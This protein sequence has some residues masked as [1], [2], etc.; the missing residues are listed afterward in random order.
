MQT[1]IFISTFNLYI[2]GSLTLYKCF[3][4]AIFVRS[5]VC[6]LCFDRITRQERVAKL[7]QIHYPIR[8][9]NFVYRLLIEQVLVPLLAIWSRAERLVM[10]GNFPCAFWFGQQ[11]IF[12]HNVHYLQ[13]ATNAPS[14]KLFLEWRLF[15]FLMAWKKPR[16]LVQTETVA[17][18]FRAA[19]QTVRNIEVI[20][21]PNPFVE[22]E[23][24]AF[25]NTRA[26]NLGALR[27]IYPALF[28]PHK[29]HRMLFECADLL[30]AENV[31]VIL[32]IARDA[33][34]GELRTR[35]KLFQ[36]VGIL[37]RQDLIE[38]YKHSD[39]L[40]FPSLEESL[41]LPL[42]EAAVLSLP[43][44]APDLSYVHS[45]IENYYSYSPASNSAFIAVIRRLKRD[46]VQGQPKIPTSKVV[47][48]AEAFVNSLLQ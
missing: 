25:T 35:D 28:Y 5:D 29:N 30:E 48:S 36:C 27:L 10:M 11:T 40:L 15:Q 16:V 14:I 47:V 23:L 37:E 31:K 33:L 39:A 2:G 9:L 7:Y 32:T 6:E 45:A 46:L 4:R 34:P 24:T 21:T 3:C 13:K 18:E 26:N 17:K 38:M 19:F 1:K 8:H 41:G 42:I 44:I 22:G 43:I 12:F 20:G